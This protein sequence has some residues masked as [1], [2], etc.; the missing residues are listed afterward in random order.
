MLYLSFGDA[1]TKSR[2]YALSISPGSYEDQGSL[3]PSQCV[4]IL[5]GTPISKLTVKLVFLNNMKTVTQQSSPVTDFDGEYLP[6]IFLLR[7]IV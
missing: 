3:V 5:C 7:Q 4:M 1:K 6:D 2:N